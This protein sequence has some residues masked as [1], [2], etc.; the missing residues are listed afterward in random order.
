MSKATLK[1]INSPSKSYQI[2][3][4]D[5]CGLE[6]EVKLL[7][8]HLKE[9]CPARIVKCPKAGCGDYVE[10]RN[11]KEHYA[12]FCLPCLRR[13]KYF[14]QKNEQEKMNKTDLLKIGKARY[15]KLGCGAIVH[16]VH[17]ANHETH[18]CQLRLVLCS[19]P[20]CGKMVPFKDLKEHETVN[21]LI[22]RRRNKFSQ[23]RKEFLSEEV[24]CHPIR[25]N[26]CGKLIKVA[27]LEYHEKH[28][29]PERLIVCPEI[30]CSERVRFSMLKTHLHMY[31]KI[32]TRRNKLVER[33]HKEVPCP[34]GCGELVLLH[35]VTEHVKHKCKLRLVYC[36]VPGCDVKVP[37]N[38]LE[39]HEEYCPVA[40]ER[41]RLSQLFKTKCKVGEPCPN[42]CESKTLT[43]HSMRMHLKYE[44]PRRL[45]PCRNFGCD[46]KVF[47]VNLQHHEL[48]TCRIAKQ[49]TIMAIESSK[50]DKIIECPLGC[51][52]RLSIRQLKLHQAEF[53]PERLVKCPHP[54]C[55]ALVS[56]S[57]LKE[58]CDKLCQ[59]PAMKQKRLRLANA[60]KRFKSVIT[61]VGK[62]NI[63]SSTLLKL[64]EQTN[65]ALLEEPFMPLIE[66]VEKAKQEKAQ[67]GGNEESSETQQEEESNEE[68]AKAPIELRAETKRKTDR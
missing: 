18:Y 15:C 22:V 47:A 55:G 14:K 67:K 66:S 2:S 57:S 35:D 7:R 32:A 53:C 45:L 1:R 38:E 10:F 64:K 58:H 20:G 62:K 34:A 6:V 21:C 41:Q 42:G 63:V 52:V 56:F 43:I 40:M 26:G 25:E 37:F 11:L 24:V 44:C 33:S 46:E 65:F 36:R 48:F 12:K 54:H 4:C 61:H 49:R 27:D 23:Q 9:S 31:C 8:Q 68:N 60:R 3:V 30:G 16:C 28:E 51:G 13:E 50:R 39:K 17:E 5:D 19:N 29:C 59:S